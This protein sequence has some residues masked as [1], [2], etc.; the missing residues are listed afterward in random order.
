[1]LKEGKE[2]Q[3]AMTEYQSFVREKE[4][5]IFELQPLVGTNYLVA[6]A[7]LGLDVDITAK[8]GVESQV[9]KVV[10]PVSLAPFGSSYLL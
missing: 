10:E 6:L 8:D 1:M 2:V 3:D 9:E 5:D 7:N 4:S